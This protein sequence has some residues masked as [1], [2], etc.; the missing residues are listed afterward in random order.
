MEHETAN[1]DLT[2][3]LAGV[4]VCDLSQ[5]IAGPHATMLLAQF[6]AEVIKV[7]PP[8]GD[9]GRLLGTQAGDHCVHSWQ[10][11]LGKKSL[12]LD[13]KKTEGKAA[14]Q[15]L[16]QTCDVFVESFRPGVAAR[17]GFSY[18]DVK[19]VRPDVIYA[20]V[21]GFGQS[22]PNSQRGTVDSLMQGFS[23]MMVMNS[24][25]QGTPHRQNMVAVD[26]LT[27]V[28]LH[29]L[30]STA[31][32]RRRIDGIGGF[33]DVS[34]MQAAAA[35][36]SAKIAEFHASGGEPQAFYGPV[37]YLPTKDGAIS[38]SCRIPAHFETLCAVVERPQLALDAR[39]DSLQGRVNNH[40]QLMECLSQATEHWETIRLL[41]ALQAAG[42]L[43][44]RVQS[45]GQWLEDP[46]V[47][48][49]K[50][51]RWQD[52]G[53]LGI[54]PLVELPG[55]ESRDAQVVQAPSVDQD[56]EQILRSLGFSDQE[57]ARTRP[58]PR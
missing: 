10:Y 41:E 36:Q 22:G 49:R 44:E 34:L 17:L 33:L 43:A 57:I 35:F 46:H 4:R 58:A 27:G 11:N 38:I 30:L 13:L 26:V 16:V 5:G 48:H 51:F 40:E 12:A 3:A 56:G 23:G 55:A 39:F 19:A 45:Y 14:L 25:A 52:A 18:E 29:S 9:W 32:H 6:G 31:L 24:T 21:S 15:R 8:E 47:R 42:V 37:G 54:L 50:A 20:S 1:V 7:E 28:Y 2:R 53:A